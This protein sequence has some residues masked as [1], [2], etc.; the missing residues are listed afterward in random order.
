MCDLMDEAIGKGMKQGL[1]Q[2][3]QKG[4][5]QGIRALVDTCKKLGVS[6]EETLKHLQEEF[7]LDA[8]AARQDMA[9]YW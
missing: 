4:L 6:F 7:S 2:G 3:E 1:E 5:Q 9:K 8:A